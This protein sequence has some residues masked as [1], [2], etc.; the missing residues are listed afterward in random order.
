[1]TPWNRFATFGFRC[2][3]IIL[4]ARVT[5]GVFHPDFSSLNLYTVRH[6]SVKVIQG[7]SDRASQCEA[8]QLDYAKP[9]NL[10]MNMGT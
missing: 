2:Y 3:R 9:V 4:P 1:M 8:R 7:L 6:R 5:Q 10:T